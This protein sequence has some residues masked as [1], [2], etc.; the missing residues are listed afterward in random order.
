MR[1]A[2]IAGLNVAPVRLVRAMNKDV[3]LIRRFDREP[4]EDG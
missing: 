1:L 4:A 3:L 2:G